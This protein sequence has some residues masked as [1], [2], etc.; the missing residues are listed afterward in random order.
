MN[1]S[2]TSRMSISLVLPSKGPIIN[3]TVGGDSIL[4][5][6]RDRRHSISKEKKKILR[7]HPFAVGCLAWSRAATDTFRSISWQ[8]AQVRIRKRHD[9]EERHINENSKRNSEGLKLSECPLFFACYPGVKEK[10]A[11]RNWMP[12]ALFKC[13]HGDSV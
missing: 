4:N 10:I 12:D 13:N 1:N 3:H 5:C 7:G 8:A 11:R 6:G 9:T 2:R